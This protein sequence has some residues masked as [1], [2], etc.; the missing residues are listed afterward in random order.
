[1][2]QFVAE[3]I[4]KKKIWKQNCNIVAFVQFLP[5]AFIPRQ[6]SFFPSGQQ[7]KIMI[8]INGFGFITFMTHKRF[9]LD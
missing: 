9:N 2:I 7:L 5:P 3:S 6:L 8:G 1:M 4:L